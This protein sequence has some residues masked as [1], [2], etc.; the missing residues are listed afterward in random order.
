MKSFVWYGFS[1]LLIS[2]FPFSSYSDEQL[3]AVC[4]SCHSSDQSNYIPNINGQSAQYLQR[5][6]L[7]YRANIVPSA[8]MPRIASRLTDQEIEWISDYFSNQKVTILPTTEEKNLPGSEIYQKKCATC[9]QLSNIGIPQIKGLPQAYLEDTMHLFKQGRR[10]MP[11]SMGYYI[12]NMTDKEVQHVVEYLSR[13]E[14]IHH[15]RG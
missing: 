7:N 2:V 6:L 12:S 4:T 14:V 11:A 10:I 5:A 8:M 3:V 9:H 15:D 13:F 1:L